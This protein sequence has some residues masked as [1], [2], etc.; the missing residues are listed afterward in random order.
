MHCLLSRRKY[1]VFSNIKIKTVLIQN[2][3]ENSFLISYLMI[4]PVSNLKHLI[5]WSPSTI[6]INHICNI[7]VFHPEL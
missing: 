2:F 3:E 1:Y 4:I 6:I 5:D 7:K